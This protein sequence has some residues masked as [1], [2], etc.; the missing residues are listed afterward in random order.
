M[1]NDNMSERAAITESELH[2]VRRQ[3][4]EALAFSDKHPRAALNQARIAVEAICKHVY[5]NEQ[6]GPG[7]S[8]FEKGNL[9]AHKM[10]LD[11]LIK[12]LDRSGA[13]PRIYLLHM[14]TVQHLGNF[15]SHDQGV[16][17]D[18]ITSKNA[19][20]CLEALS[21]VVD[22]YFNDYHRGRTP[23]SGAQVSVVGQG[24]N[25]PSATLDALSRN[26]LEGVRDEFENQARLFTMLKMSHKGG[27]SAAHRGAMPVMSLDRLVRAKQAGGAGCISLSSFEKPFGRWIVTGLPGSGKSTML[28]VLASSMASSAL[29][30]AASRIQLPIILELGRYEPGSLLNLTQVRESLGRF[31]RQTIPSAYVSEL[32]SN[33]DIVWIMDGLDEGMIGC[34]QVND[35]P[36]WKEIEAL[37]PLHPSHSFIISTR[38]THVPAGANFSTVFIENLGPAEVRDF[39]G[40]YLAYFEVGQGPDAIL[41]AIPA[42][43]KEVATT[44][45]VLSMV[46]SAYISTGTVPG[47]LDQLY[48]AFVT[49]TLSEVEVARRGRV[50]SQVKDMTLAALAFEML[51]SSKPILKSAD[52]RTVIKRRTSQLTDRGEAESAVDPSVI[53]D[54]LIYSGLL[55]R[56]DYQI[57]FVHLTMME[58]FAACE[59][60]REYNFSA[61]ADMDQ[62]FLRNLDKI[63][64]ITAAAAITAEDHLVEVGAGIGSVAKHFPPSK[65]LTLI[66]LDPDLVKILRYQFPGIQVLEVDALK[67]LAELPCDILVSNLPF[68]LTDGILAFLAEKQF[69]RAVMS[70]RADDVFDSFAGKL[71]I[72]TIATLVE[73]DFFPRQPFPSKVILVT[74]IPKL[75]IPVA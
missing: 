45:L 57:S 14:T 59:M 46:V 17:A 65:S 39:I 9:P 67:A 6:L 20:T 74:P 27:D 61:Q 31:A 73:E 29:T 55:V 1:A 51:T 41:A 66:D 28:R 15:G 34:T 36:L 4:E 24:V 63:K 26:Y 25:G 62:Y 71:S 58:Y 3:Y 10:E 50:S 70:V 5:N 7:G 72:T 13:V 22:W 60:S 30:S 23:T 49:H 44:P 8:G 37:L 43:L 16:E 18:Q 48:R 42:G 40:R 38:R 52:A 32:L 53:L 19:Q 54:E 12:A 47:S 64:V 21:T 2:R 75:S 11:A 69:K 35:T 33:H 56:Q 68:F